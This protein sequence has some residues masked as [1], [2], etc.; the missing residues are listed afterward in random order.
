MELIELENGV[1]IAL[2]PMPGLATAAVGVW[3]RVGARWET[4]ETGGVAHLFEHMAFKGAGGRDAKAFAEAM[5]N[6]GASMNASTSFERTSYYARCLSDDTPAVLELIADVILAP[7]WEAAELA[8]EKQ[9]VLQEIGEAFDQPDDRVFE[10]H[11][12]EVFAGQP[13]GR[14]IL[15]VAE[16]LAGIEVSTLESFRAAH[17]TGARVVIAVAGAYDRAAL[18]ETA[19]RR[20][21][22][23]PAGIGAPPSAARA[24]RGGAS[25]AR[26]LEQAHLVFSWPA[27][28]S[29]EDQLPAARV[30]AEVLGGG[31]SS[32]LFQEVREK[33]GLVYSIDAGLDVYEDVGRL[34]VAAG[35][36]AKDADE[37]G[38]VVVDMLAD[39]AARGPTEAE[40]QRARVTFA[41]SMLMG[42]E[43]PL[44]RAESRAQQVFL[45]GRLMEFSELKALIDRVTMEDVRA[46]AAAAMQGPV[47]AAAIGP[48]AGLK[49]VEAFM[50]RFV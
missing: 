34:V 7:H 46:Q 2:D 43:R 38:A 26:K 39:L 14:P 3:V 42:A 41:A 27:P 1:R 12:A 13:L 29:G 22:G 16:T 15:G 47:G 50:A 6:M 44:S 36:A 35:C 32:R 40:L 11:Q 18:L 9:V 17:L 5:E 25:E 20:F 33:R 23:V 28:A 37:V 8:K 24:L 30:L 45:R 10:L 19:R 49:A 4:P 31:M 48:K 21:D